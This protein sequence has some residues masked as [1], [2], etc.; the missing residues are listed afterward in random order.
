MQILLNRRVWAAGLVGFLAVGCTPT[1]SGGNP[2]QEKLQID[3]AGG[4]YQ[5]TVLA[6]DPCYIV[7]DDPEVVVSGAELRITRSLI[8]EDG[9]CATVITPLE[10]TGPLPDVPAGVTKFVLHLRNARGEVVS[11]LATD[12]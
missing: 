11:T 4:V 9:I 7:G 12:L 2:M 1:A 5:A 6:P 8:R 3:R 10:V